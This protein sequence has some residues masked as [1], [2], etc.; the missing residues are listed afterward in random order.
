MFRFRRDQKIFEIGDVKIGGKPENHTVLVGSI[1]YQGQKIVENEEK[2]IFDRK[3]AEKLIELQEDFSEKTGIPGMFDV[4][5]MS[6]Q[7]MI[8][9]VN[10]VSETTD[11]PFLIDSPDIETRISGIRHAGEV[12][13]EKK[14]VYNS[15]TSDTGVRELEAISEYGI[16]SAILLLYSR[17]FSTSSTR[18]ETLEKLLPVAETAGISKPLVD[19]LVI[20]VPSLSFSIRA[21][22]E[23]KKRYGLPCGCGAHN[24]I[25]S[26]R[27]F[28]NI[29]GKEG[30]KSAEIT[31]NI[32]PVVLGA[33]FILYGPV[34]SC[35]DV[36]P[37]VYTVDTSLRYLL[38]K[39]EE[40]VF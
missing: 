30:R 3:E 34:E 11:T 36:F 22:L 26:W 38:R 1:F 12:G 39:G 8:R 20:D 19:T 28:E 4:V 24:A 37:G 13:L 2:G 40:I 9:Y 5:A 31:A 29:I 6:P 25:S 32:M 35:T 16:E 14:V 15:I 23:I 10:F 21:M 33:D 18:I 27:G 7:A 17:G